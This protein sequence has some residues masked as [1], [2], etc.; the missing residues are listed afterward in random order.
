MAA[1]LPLVSKRINYLKAC[2]RCGIESDK[3]LKLQEEAK[4]AILNT[5]VSYRG[6]ISVE[7]A[8]A[9]ITCIAEDC[10]LFTT[11]C[12]QVLID[13]ITSKTR[14]CDMGCVNYID[15]QPAAAA[16]VLARRSKQT[17]YHIENY[18]THA[19]WK[20][21]REAHVNRQVVYTQIGRLLVHLG[22]HRPK[23]KF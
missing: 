21:L 20:G 13:S 22:L 2:S 3:W 14:D 7:I 10:T 5:L 15:E 9:L 6:A 4:G 19:I 12:R 16:T 11:D 18:L 23:Q 17:L 8:S 1:L